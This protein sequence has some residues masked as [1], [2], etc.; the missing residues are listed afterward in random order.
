MQF[1]F[2]RAIFDL[3]GT[4]LCS[5]HRQLTCPDGTLNLSHWIE[6]STPEKVLKDSVLPIAD[7]MRKSFNKN[8]ETLV[9]TA[10]VMGDV[11]FLL[12]KKH[13]LNYHAILHRPEG[14]NTQD[15]LLKEIQLRLYAQ[16]RGISWKQFIAETIM[17]DDS[18]SVLARM[19]EIGL[20]CFNAVEFN[21]ILL[22]RAA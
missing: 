1:S 20:K 17:F 19:S 4:V 16:S 10:R 11:D 21:Q 3:D 22:R 9:C 13:E 15:A 8:Y 18:A 6:N 7:I 12:L 14:C 2:N 5:K